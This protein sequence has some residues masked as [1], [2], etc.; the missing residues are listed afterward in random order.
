MRSV[1][2]CVGLFSRE[3]RSVCV[4]VIV[5]VVVPVADVGRPQDLLGAV[6]SKAAPSPPPPPSN[7]LLGRYW[8]TTRSGIHHDLLRD[9]ADSGTRRRFP[10]VVLEINTCGVTELSLIHI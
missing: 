4:V 5:V 3:Q 10:A 2:P 7:R 1:Q 6:K 9:S 8:L